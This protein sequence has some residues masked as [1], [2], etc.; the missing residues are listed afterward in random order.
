VSSDGK[1][2]TFD[3]SGL[4]TG[5]KLNVVIAP[6]PAAAPPPA[7]LPAPPPSPPTFDATFE[8]PDA[9]AFKVQPVAAPDETVPQPAPEAVAPAADLGAAPSSASLAPALA[10]GLVAP[11]PQVVSPPQATATPR[12]AFTNVPRR[13]VPATARRSFGDSAVI[14][15]MLA[16]ALLALAREAGS[17]AGGRRPRLSLYEAPKP[18]EVSAV[19]RSGSP[20]P[21][22]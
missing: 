7:P 18:V 20:P 21:L 9:A 14:A 8:K 3:L 17:R 2:V 10:A 6:A 16:I 5:D 13:L 4:V 1:H 19:G 22:R 11:P 15:V 12:A